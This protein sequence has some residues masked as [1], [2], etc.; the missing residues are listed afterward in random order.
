MAELWIAPK[1]LFDDGRLLSG[2]AVQVA[3]GCAVQV[4]KQEDCDAAIHIPHTIAPGFVD[5]QVNGGGGVLL[6]TSPH[7]EG[8]MAIAKAH[9]A[10]GTVAIMPTVITDAPEVLEA[11][12]DA[13]IA[14]R[15]LAGVVGLHIEG[16]HID[17]QKRGTHAE[18]Y[19]RPLDATTLQV[20]AELRAAEVTVLITLA[21]EA[22]TPDQITALT[23][24]G[25]IVSLGHSNCDARTARAAFAAGA[26]CVTHLFNAMSQ[27]QGRAPGLTGAA[28]RSTAYVSMICDGVHVA[29]DMLGLALDARPSPDLSF[30]V[31]DAMPTVG[32]PDHFT[33]YDQDIRLDA[34]RL[35]NEEGNLA[36]AHTTMAEG[37][38]RLVQKVGRTPETALRMAISTPAR[39]VGAPKLAQVAGRTLSDL[40]VLDGELNLIGSLAAVIDNQHA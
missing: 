19:V 15:D 18:A 4:A 14:A 6:N 36:G 1:L 9:H 29:D 26:S 30:L 12:A 16:P 34:G 35:V 33:L 28:I 7:L 38:T 2:M 32:G 27:M 39:V 31:S 22:A 17:P 8:I 37:V 10:L 24:Q 21:P 3:S 5:L 23:G 13:A 40:M 11:A 25:V 20:I